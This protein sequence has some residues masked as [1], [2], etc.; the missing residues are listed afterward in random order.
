LAIAYNNSI[1]IGSWATSTATISWW[2]AVIIQPAYHRRYFGRG[3]EWIIRL[4]LLPF[5]P[6]AAMKALMALISG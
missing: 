3:V 5:T 2:L 4:P 6:V 1:N